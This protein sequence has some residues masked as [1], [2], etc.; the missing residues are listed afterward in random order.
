DLSTQ[1]LVR[2]REVHHMSE[3]RLN[4]TQG[5]H[6]DNPVSGSHEFSWDAA[7]YGPPIADNWRL[8]A[9]NR[10]AKGN[11]DEGKGSSRQLFGG[12]EW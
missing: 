7:I 11:F 3:L 2:A 1:K 6:S 12:I 8:F 10:C 4:S 5:I 9:G